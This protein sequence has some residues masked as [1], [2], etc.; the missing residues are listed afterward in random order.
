MD[1]TFTDEQRLMTS[2][3]REL[4]DDICSSAEMRAAFE[5]ETGAAATRWGLA[6]FRVP[7]GA[8]AHRHTHAAAALPHDDLRYWLG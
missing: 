2:S 6:I 7:R 1:F 3:Y 4:T 8:P 5:G